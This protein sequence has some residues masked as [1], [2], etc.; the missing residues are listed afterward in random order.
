[1]FA[2]S[3]WSLQNASPGFSTKQVVAGSFIL[4]AQRYADLD[5]Q[6]HL[7]RELEGRL[8]GMPGVVAAAITDTLPPAGDPRSVP[9]VALVGGGDASADGLQGLVKWRYITP[10]F[11]RVMGIPVK[12][13]RG[14]TDSDRA[15]AQQPVVISESLAKRRFGDADPIGQPLRLGGLSEVI[16]GVVGDVRNAGLHLPP[17]PEFYVL[18]SDRVNAVAQNQRPP[19]GWR[20]ATAIIRSTAPPDVALKLLQTAIWESEPSVAI[21]TSTLQQQVDPLYAR[22]RLQAA[23]FTS[24]ALISLILAGI[25]LYGLTSYLASKRAREIGIRMAVGATRA[26][27]VRLLMRRGIVMVSVGLFAGIVVSASASNLLR[28]FLFG[29]D[30]LDAASYGLSTALLAAVALVGLVV[31]ALRNSSGSLA[32]RLRDG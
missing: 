30:P 28:S 25:S 1:M 13:G 15:S 2:K 9:Y 5:R 10:G 32:S 23:L 18:R 26:D 16:V 6:R 22:P 19:H 3:L 17:D 29:L 27:I 12:R 8:T 24:F 11:F 14:F 20:A 21:V 4:P 7:F 31:P